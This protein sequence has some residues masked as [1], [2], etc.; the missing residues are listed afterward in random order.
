MHAGLAEAVEANGVVAVIRMKEPDKLRAVVD[1]LADGGVR[2][3]EV[4][5]TVPRAIELIG[6]LAPTLP[7]GFL[8]GAG[9]VLDP[10]TA[11]AAI[12]AGAEF[13][14]GPNVNLHVI[15]L[16][17][18]YG[19][20]VFPGAF[21]PTEVVSAWEAGADI[22]VD[23]SVEDIVP[24]VM[25]ETSG[26]GA[27]VVIETAGRPATFYQSIDLI[28]E[29]GSIWLGSF[30]SGPFMFDPSLPRPT[31][32]QS[33]LTQKH[34]IS[35]HCPWLT[36]GDHATRRKQAMD[37]IHSGVVTA[38]RFVSHYYPLDKIKEA[39]EAS[40]NP[41]ESIKVIVEPG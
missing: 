30:Y 34:G 15:R 19:K 38:D 22:A 36:F 20:L 32:P 6:Q 40:L 18:R 33:N 3:L 12:L 27:D 31:M 26:K 9:T 1:A 16:A 24:I 41:Y 39:F 28:K 21:T 13:L 23:E 17:R 25:K 35:I 8:L 29:Q 14:V 11:R 2:A 10:E 4:T 7:P 5:M 37:L